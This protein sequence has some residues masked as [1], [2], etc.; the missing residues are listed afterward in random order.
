M[1]RDPVDDERQLRTRLAELRPYTDEASS[2]QKIL[3][4][5]E[6]RFS[7]PLL[8]N[9]RLASP[10]SMEWDAMAGDERVRFCGR[11]RKNVYNLSAM[12]RP[13]AERLVFERDGELCA[14]FYRRS[15]G[16]VLTADCPTGRR[17]VRWLRG[18]LAA[19]LATLLASIGWQPVVLPPR[20]LQAPRPSPPRSHPQLA[21]WQ[22]GAVG[23][24]YPRPGSAFTGFEILDNT[25]LLPEH[26]PGRGERDQ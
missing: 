23:A 6:R 2:I 26:R 16:T 3:T 25:G 12:T 15:D 24:L 4:A 21:G 13:E 8:D 9:L 20:R 17:R 22:G 11:C 10:C 7:L 19:A 5:R 1:Y 18:V 14:R